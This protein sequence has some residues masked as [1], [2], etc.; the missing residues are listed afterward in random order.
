M[1]KSDATALLA[2]ASSFDKRTVGPT[3][4]ESWAV[5]LGDA[6]A[7]DCRDA[8]V[9]HYQSSREFLMPVDVIEGA[10]R[11]RNNRLAGIEKPIP[12]RELADL[13]EAS[14]AWTRTFEHAICD[15]AN[16][17]DAIAGAN[18]AFRITDDEPL[19]IESG[20]E[21]IAAIKVISMEVARNKS[22]SF[23][24][25]QA[26]RAEESERYR[27]AKAQRRAEQAEGETA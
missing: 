11:I 16:R 8:I 7:V 25:V 19:A 26:K 6:R 15:G 13:A 22:F 23:Q 24:E 4:V 17:A 1:I 21:A 9:A 3:D 14:M 27:V 10:R 12:P 18:V 20:Q 5:A 2:V